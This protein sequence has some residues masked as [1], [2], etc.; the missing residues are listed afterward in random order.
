MVDFFKNTYSL[1]PLSHFINKKITLFNLILQKLF[2]HK[3]IYP[4]F[5]VNIYVLLV[6]AIYICTGSV[7]KSTC[8]SDCGK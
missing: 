4:H 2:V 1:C 3:Q 8:I 6:N 5:A 7:K